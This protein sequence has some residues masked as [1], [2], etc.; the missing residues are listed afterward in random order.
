MVALGLWVC[1]AATQVS[2]GLSGFMCN[3][4][5][6]T[7]SIL[8]FKVIPVHMQCVFL[9]V[10]FKELANKSF[11]IFLYSY[12]MLSVLKDLTSIN[13]S[14]GVLNNLEGCEGILRPMVWEPCHAVFG[15]HCRIPLG[16]T[17][18]CPC[19]PHLS[20]SHPCFLLPPKASYLWIP[21]S[22]AC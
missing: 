21:W 18:S 7:A 1:K 17:V 20:S 3:P 22:P 9:I 8:I 19:P 6:S 10:T 5:S 13:E 16:A 12:L 11:I 2:L 4:F 15:H 14:T